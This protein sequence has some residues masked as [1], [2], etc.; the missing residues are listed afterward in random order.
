[1]NWGLNYSSEKGQISL[2]GAEDAH[3]DHSTSSGFYRY[4][5]IERSGIR[6]SQG[7]GTVTVLWSKIKEVTI[8]GVLPE[9]ISVVKGELTLKSG[10]K[11]PF[12]VDQDHNRNHLAQHLWPPRTGLTMKPEFLF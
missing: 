11:L 5:D 10:K 7:A 3:F 9:N 4:P 6:I 1:L 2:R 8:T 12:Q